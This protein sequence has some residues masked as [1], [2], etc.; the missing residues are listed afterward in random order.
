MQVASRKF[1][2]AAKQK[3][4]EWTCKVEEAVKISTKPKDLRPWTMWG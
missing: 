2:Q 3:N 1:W 4:S